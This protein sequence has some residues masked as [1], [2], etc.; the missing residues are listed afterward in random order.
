VRQLRLVVTGASGFVG[1]HLL[2]VLK[3]DHLIY[4]L[5]R[6][7]QERS[8]API[9]P[10]I[11]W[12]QADIADWTALEAIFRTIAEAGGADALVHLAA[13]YDF[14]GEAYAEY[15]RTNVHGMRNVVELGRGLG[16][17]RFVFPSSVAAC[18]F[19]APGAALTEAS[20][21]DG[22][23]IYARTKRAGEEMLAALQAELPSTV[24]RFAAMF[25]DWCEYPPLYMF[26]QTWLSSMWNR[27]VLGGRGLSAIP[28]L[29]IRDGTAFIRTLLE[30]LDEVPS[31]ETLVASP[32][33]PVS[34]HELF[35]AATLLFFRE[36]RRP[37]LMPR[38]LCG[39]GIWLRDATGRLLGRRPFERFWMYRYIDRRMTV[40]AARTRARL[41]WAPRT[42]LLILR[43]L[44]FVVE[45]MKG[46]PVE[47]GRRNH[48]AL[49]KVRL[50]THLVVYNLLRRHAQ[51]IASAFTEALWGPAGRERFPSFQV[52][53]T[54]E[55][56]TGDDHLL[57]LRYLIEAVRTGESALFVAYC[58]EVAE[59]RFAQGFAAEEIEDALEE[60]DRVC[61][62]TLR[63]DPDA[64]P[65]E[66][67]VR[68]HVTT[69]LRW[70]SDAV[71]D[72]FEL[73]ATEG[74][75]GLFGDNGLRGLPR[76]GEGTAWSEPS[77]RS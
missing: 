61:L 24:I 40:N 54:G 11:R 53:L 4:A 74:R 56:R 45:N 28:Y 29:H 13:H 42:R 64:Q 5:A 58:R 52:G 33:E 65:F 60:L 35:A 27:R 7:S 23:H 75:S 32:D 36:R 77:R 30:R 63:H 49:R 8:R 41:G 62:R 16:L 17:R 55:E 25:S 50:R 19:P 38:L 57:L 34:H 6:R 31:G 67:D 3:D 68:D 20:P 1:R 71:Q 72:V 10:N 66:S 70:G 43:R 39:P 44:P 46:D 2:D 18:R 76:R 15:W 47:W 26:L 37:I 51:Q 48:A 73:L 21:P 22:D 12:F 69:T 9:H 14:T 59:R